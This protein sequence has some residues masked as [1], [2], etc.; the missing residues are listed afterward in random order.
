MSLLTDILRLRAA[1][2][3]AASRPFPPAARLALAA[4]ALTLLLA[5]LESLALSAQR[6]T[7]LVEL[8]APEAGLVARGFH[9]PEQDGARSFRWSAGRSEVQILNTGLGG[10]RV[11]DLRLGAGPADRPPPDL[12]LSLDG[13]PLATL[14]VDGRPRRY[15]LL[16][17][18]TA[19]ASGRVTVGLASE[20]F[21]APPDTRPLGLRVEA[22]ALDALGEGAVLPAPWLVLAQGLL[23]SCVAYALAR[24]GWRSPA[25]LAAL[26]LAAAGLALAQRLPPAMIAPM[27][28]A[29]LAGAAAALAGL[30]ALLLPALERQPEWIGSARAARALWAA[31]LLACALRLV[32]TLY[33]P[34][35]AYDL[36]LNLGRFVRTAG[37]ALVDANRSFE[38]RSGVTVYPA[39]PYLALMP[40]VLAGLT[41]K[42]AVQGG[43]ALVDGMGALA[44]GA[45]AVRLRLGART[46]LYAALLYAALPVMLTSLWFGHTAQVFGQA[47]VAP[48]AL[49]LLAALA[50]HRRRAWLTAGALLSMALLSHIGVT[51]L[52]LAWLGLAWLALARRAPGRAWRS[53]GVMLAGSTLVGL[54]LVYGPA[55]QLKLA[56]LGKVGER[57]A[58]GGGG[59]AYNLIL[60]AFRISFY[61]PGWA[62][63]LL[64]VGL[65][66]WRRMPRGG[67]ALLGAW[68]A[69]AGLFLAVELVTALQVRYLVML[70]PL[71]CIGVGAVLAG[72]AGRGG[73]GRAVAWA[74]TAGLL[75]LGAATWYVGVYQNVQMSMVPLL[76]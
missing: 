26:A 57:V 59:P 72:I 31:A 8:G 53:F 49:A 32:G 65:L 20:T 29:R 15:L 70:A 63:A 64:G 25:V 12:A 51:I 33:P 23:L 16:A 36:S 22:V 1:A 75:A 69:A 68:L 37:G 76:R 24:S 52:A 13:Q 45:L 73:A 6:P 56:E 74:A 71:A 14:A 43:I 35:D 21:T 5:L 48:L 44:T 42:L 3:R 50:S 2:P 47:L 54:A 34:F 39:G 19:A 58:E 27:Y 9:A 46:A 66:S 28:T 18:S 7:A 55:A 11:L 67:P 38:F 10:A 30:T 4:V 40:G 62:L 41:P 17:P 60:S 61:E